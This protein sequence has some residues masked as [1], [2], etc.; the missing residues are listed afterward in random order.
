MAR[1]SVVCAGISDTELQQSLDASANEAGHLLRIEAFEDPSVVATFVEDRRPGQSCLG[2]FEHEQLEEVPVLVRRHT[3]FLVVVALVER[4]KILRPVT[5][6]HPG[7][8]Y[9]PRP[10]GP[11]TSS[12]G[13]DGRDQP[14]SVPMN[15][16]PSVPGIGILRIR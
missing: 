4:R 3:P 12:P 15:S 1:D 9:R 11:A 7:R 6:L 16:I 14:V 8:W 10:V 5:P 13:A 2:S